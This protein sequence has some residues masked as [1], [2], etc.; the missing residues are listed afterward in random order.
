MKKI[1]TI[2]LPKEDDMDAISPME[3]RSL[4]RNPG[5]TIEPVRV[6]MEEVEI[7]ARVQDI[8]VAGIGFLTRQRLEPGTWLVLEPA[9]LNQGL[10][11]ELRAEVRHTTQWDKE[12]LVGCRFSRFLTTDDAMALG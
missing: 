12:Y 7:V 5:H 3:R 10:T 4:L 1:V 8:S 2:S 11:P 6:R 9:E